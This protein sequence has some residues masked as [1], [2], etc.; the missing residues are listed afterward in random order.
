MPAFNLEYKDR[1]NIFNK[2]LFTGQ[3]SKLLI[4]VEGEGAEIQE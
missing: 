3:A 1:V 4:Q 2:Q